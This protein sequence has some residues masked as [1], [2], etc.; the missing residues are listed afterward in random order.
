[1]GFILSP[2]RNQILRSGLGLCAHSAVFK[3]V[4]HPKRTISRLRAP[5]RPGGSARCCRGRRRRPGRGLTSRRGLVRL[6]T[7]PGRVC[8]GGPGKPPGL[9][10]SPRFAPGK[11]DPSAPQSPP[12]RARCREGLTAGPGDAGCPREG[13]ALMNRSSLITPLRL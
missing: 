7:P 4:L 12:L 5:L 10:L 2:F 13:A 3:T 11:S 6:Q 9:L 1:M 8:G